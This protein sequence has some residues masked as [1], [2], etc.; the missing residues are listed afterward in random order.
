[1]SK[2]WVCSL[3]LSLLMLALPPVQAGEPSAL[4]LTLEQNINRDWR[5][6][7]GDVARAQQPELDDSTW[8][9]VHLPHDFS[10]E[11]LPDSS[12]KNLPGSNSPFSADSIDKFDTGYTL[13][14]VGWY[15]KTVYLPAELAQKVALLEFGGVYM[16]S[17]VYVNGQLAGGQHYGYTTFH[18]DISRYLR[19]G[20]NNLLAVK[21]DNKHLN[22][23]WYSGSGIYRPVS[24]EFYEKTYFARHG[25]AISTEVLAKQQ[26][27]IK[28]ATDLVNQT[29]ASTELQLVTQ[30]VDAQGKLVAE[31]KTASLSMP[32]AKHTEAVT[33]TIDKAQLWSDQT[34]YLYQLQQTLLR[35]GQTIARQTI[36]FGI[37]ALVFDANKGLLVNGQPV[38]LKGMNVHHDNYLL[39]AAAWPAAELRKVQMIKAAGYNAIRTSHNPP[40]QAFLDAADR[41]GVYIID[42]AFDA[43][44]EKKWDHVNDY[45]SR[46]KQDWQRDLTNFIKRDRNHPSVIM[47]SIGNEIPEQTSTLGVATAGEL[48]G[49]VKTIDNTRPVTIGANVSGIEADALL[50]QFGVVGYNYQEKN[51]R[52]D[53]QRNPTRLMYGSETYSAKAF[54]YWDFVE[55]HPFVIGDFV[56][57]GWDYIGEASIGWTGYAPEWKGLADFPWTLA[58][59]GE[60]D[61][62]G[63]QRPSA[64]YRD[65]LWQTGKNQVSMFVK[66]PTPSLAPQ[67][68]PDWYLYWVQP[69]LHPNWTWPGQEG[70]PL[71]VV[72]YSALP[73]VEVFLNGQSL[74]KKAT[75]RATHYT[76]QFVVPYGAGELKAVAYDAQHKVAA[77]WVLHTAQQVSE[78]R[79]SA[80][81]QSIKA[82]GEDLVYIS[83]EL[84]DK[85]GNPVY[86]WGQDLQL[87]FSVQGAGKL[88]ALGNADPRSVEGFSG[89]Q[90]R[91]FRGRAVA[92]VQS[93]PAQSGA[94]TL[95]V[96]SQSPQV[97]A[98]S[99]TLAS[100]AP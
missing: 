27:S 5:F 60:L 24:L 30:V 79:L 69:D 38:K 82:D 8:R 13:G 23:R 98:A 76:A 46:F 9:Q 51:Y 42:E 66:S 20:K 16:N 68:N 61:A 15:R 92:V 48:I 1:M 6:M 36:P 100:R 58:Y 45:S 75:S 90:R 80:N 12:I 73:Q 21:V 81:Q 89:S 94:I 31:T 32:G 59:C 34:P 33:L 26:A 47:W 7:R 95:V 67:Q 25:T 50:N 57:T 18:I 49:F 41:L 44:N 4:A 56:W 2:T 54:E 70:K 17:E 87:E 52:S 10:I 91:T 55:R 86:H 35:D 84:L 99:L 43:W 14:G 85:N 72:V 65:V 40:S 88:L 97:K 29:G 19:P 64:Y 11:N 93:L 39:G 71:E 53:R 28:V 37:R 62:L 77:E 74:G 22:S 96:S 78:I 3:L 83:A 63:Y